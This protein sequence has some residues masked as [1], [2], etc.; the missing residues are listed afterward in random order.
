MESLNDYIITIWKNN[1]SI[2]N[3][4]ID[5]LVKREMKSAFQMGHFDF[6]GLHKPEY[7]IY[8]VSLV[9]ITIHCN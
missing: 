3:T 7:Y 6:G 5:I 2:N 1:K 8:W 4:E 9:K